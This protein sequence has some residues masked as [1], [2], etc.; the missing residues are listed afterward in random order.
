MIFRCVYLQKKNRIRKTMFKNDIGFKKIQSIK[1]HSV[2]CYSPMDGNRCA[3]FNLSAIL[4][5][6]IGL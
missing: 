6:S 3:L 4:L 5:P 2:V 1:L